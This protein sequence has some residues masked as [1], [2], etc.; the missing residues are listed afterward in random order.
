[1]INTW[2]ISINFG[3]ALNI[4]GEF[5]PPPRSRALINIRLRSITR[6]MLQ[7]RVYIVYIDF[8]N[9]TELHRYTVARLGKTKAH[10]L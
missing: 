7:K 4:F 2:C 10:K 1:M 3:G 8:Q 6:V 5:K 9:V